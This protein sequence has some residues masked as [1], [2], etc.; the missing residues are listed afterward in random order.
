MTNFKILYILIFY[1]FSIYSISQE[2]IEIVY[3]AFPTYG[4]IEN[5]G[6]IKRSKANYIYEGLDESIRNTEYKL[7][8]SNN[9]YYYFYVEKIFLDEKSKRLAKTYCG[10]ENFY[11]EIKLDF[12]IKEKI[13]SN[14]TYF[15]R[16]T[17]KYDW[18][19]SNEQK[20]ID[21]RIC[22][23]A[24]TIEKKLING[25]VVNN[26]I[27]AWFCPEIPISFGPKGFDGLPGLILELSDD[28]V[29]LVAKTITK[30]ENVF[31]KKINKEE[32]ISEIDF[33]KIVESIRKKFLNSV[34][35]DK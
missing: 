18:E 4:S 25:K 23:K 31:V 26:F 12:K 33:S 8:I 5:D 27:T 17:T 14:K 13:F 6:K 9:V 2:N 29:T 30:K 24:S 19:I 1:I 35:I 11:K 21:N 10:S 15:I 7:N 28:K 20:I 16:D 34:N 32:T 3:N 22:F